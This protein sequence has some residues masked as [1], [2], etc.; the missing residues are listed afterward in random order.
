[1]MARRHVL[2]H[3][4]FATASEQQPVSLLKHFVQN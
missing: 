4:M 2:C 1:M 3:M